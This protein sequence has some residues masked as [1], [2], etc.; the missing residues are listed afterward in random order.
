MQN[1]NVNGY[2]L[3]RPLGKGGMAEVW[4][5]ENTLGKAAAVKIL[6]PKFCDEE[7][8]VNRF[9]NEAG[10]MVSLQHPNIRQAY[11]YGILD[12][13]PCMI[14]EYLEGEDLSSRMKNGERF[15]Q[16]QLQ[17]WWNQLVSALN[18]T[19]DKGVVHRDIKPSNIFID[20]AGNVKLLD[21]GIAKVQ[22]G[23]VM[24]QTGATMG[25][26]LYMSPEQVEDSK[27]IDSKTDLYS[28]AVTFLHLLQGKTPYDTTTTSDYQ[29]RKCIV[30]MPLDLTGIPYEWQSL[31]EPYLA[32][33]PEE[34]PALVP[35]GTPATPNATAV[36]S[37]L[38]PL[39]PVGSS[40][41]N[42]PQHSYE[43]GTRME[44]PSPQPASKT[45]VAQTEIPQQ[46]STPKKKK[47]KRTGLVIGLIIGVLVLAGG[48]TAAWFWMKDK[49]AK[50]YNVEES[51][52]ERYVGGHASEFFNARGPVKSIVEHYVDQDGDECTYSFAF[53][54]EGY[55]TEG[56]SNEYG[57]ILEW[58][59][60]YSN[61]LLVNKSKSGNVQRILPFRPI[62]DGG[63][64]E[65]SLNYFLYN[66]FIDDD[67]WCVVND[68][69]HWAKK[70]PIPYSSTTQITSGSPDDYIYEIVGEGERAQY[71][72][73]F[74][75]DEHNNLIQITSLEKRYN[76]YWDEYSE[77]YVCDHDSY[78]TFTTTLTFHY[79]SENRIISSRTSGEYNSSWSISYNSRGDAERIQYSG[80]GRNSLNITYDYDGYDNWI[81]R[82]ITIS[83]D[84]NKPI[85]TTR[86]IEY[87]E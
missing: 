31:L 27:H 3:L 55:L 52:E 19:H 38:P 73:S 60:S 70:Y 50:K 33:N 85:K 65:V 84:R 9:R 12:G 28:L 76:G 42:A 26:L 5:A 8:I 51:I 80:E 53:D 16:E 18:Y 21:F 72:F 46:S 47:K 66:L 29:I 59:Y 68:G 64:G 41:S 32:K 4:Y 67:L 78:E 77:E 17:R 25:T 15:T 23:M 63:L 10:V 57:E 69:E 14:M 34:R 83:S 24:T 6:L 43:D 87:Y 79:D 86:E 36:R 7:N 61:D 11:D 82:T 37:N 74:Q 22:D 81:S 49:K 30:E 2:T 56:E 44:E 1:K 45:M 40:I 48:G 35:F 20:M 58:T 71:T 75:Y 62:M 13:R 39:P 54:E